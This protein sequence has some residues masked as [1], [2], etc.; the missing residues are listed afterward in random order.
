MAIASTLAQR[1]PL[2][3]ALCKQAIDLSFDTT[4]DDALRRA[5]PLSDR[6]FSSAEAQEGVRAFFAKQSP[7]FAASEL[8]QPSKD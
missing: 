8:R 3:L 5:L 7:Q 4:E 6:A 2:A 1:P